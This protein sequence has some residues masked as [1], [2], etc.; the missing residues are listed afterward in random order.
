MAGAR[1][2]TADQARVILGE[3]AADT[4]RTEAE[5]WYSFLQQRF[6]EAERMPKYHRMLGE[7]YGRLTVHLDH[8]DTQT[9]LESLDWM[10]AEAQFFANH[11]A[12]PIELVG[13]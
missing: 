3:A 12:F 1:I 11:P 5:R 10:R 13:E 2:M 9:A 8:G 6:E 4:M 7:A